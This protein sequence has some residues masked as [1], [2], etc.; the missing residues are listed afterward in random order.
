MT[1]GFSLLASYCSVSDCLNDSPSCRHFVGC[2]IVECL[3]EILA[4]GVGQL[5]H[6]RNT[7][8]QAVNPSPQ[9]IVRAR[10]QSWFVSLAAVSADARRVAGRAKWVGH[11]G[12]IAFTEK[13]RRAE[14]GLTRPAAPKR[15][16]PHVLPGVVSPRRAR[17]SLVPACV[18]RQAG[19]RGHGVGPGAAPGPR[20]AKSPAQS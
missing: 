2:A 17:G 13:G 9:P 1:Q 5:A 16:I 4:A 14:K 18:Q 6:S 20:G 11:G 12:V 8:L 10:R 15:E 7:P 19:R 3:A